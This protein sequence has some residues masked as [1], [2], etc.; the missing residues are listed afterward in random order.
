MRA[1]PASGA[2]VLEISNLSCIRG[3]RT[4]F[5]D[6]SF[7]LERG[8]LLRVAGA[9]GS[10]KTSLLRI[11]CGLMQPAEGE[12]RWGGENIRRLREDYWQDLS[13]IGHLNGLKDDLTAIENLAIGAALAG[14]DI[15]HD[16]ALAA[17]AA[18]G[19]AHCA[20][21]PARVLSQGQRRRIALARLIAW[22]AAPLWVLDEPFPGLDTA[23]VSLISTVIAGHVEN[24]GSVILTTHQE[25]PIDAAIQQRLDL[26][27]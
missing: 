7:T 10:G 21:L 6:L 22:K 26:S 12:V 8:A 9:N 1:L 16:A 19:I 18:L 5:T 14:R 15:T 25:V 27:A 23:A 3:E 24:G 4:L 13:Y 17:L 11:V 20:D 2:A